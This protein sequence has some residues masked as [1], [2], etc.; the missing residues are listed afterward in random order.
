M[1]KSDVKK[2]KSRL[3]KTGG[4]KQSKLAEEFNISRSLVSDIWTE[5]AH[6]DVPWPGGQRPSRTKS[7]GQRKNTDYDPTDERIRGLEAE[8]VLLQDELRMERKRAK[9]NAKS[10]GLFKSVVDALENE[11]DPFSAL[12]KATRLKSARGAIREHCV[13]H[14][15]DGHHDQIVVPDECGGL[16]RYDFPISCA[17]AEKYVDTVLKWTQRTLSPQFR[18][19][20]L[21]ILAYGDHTSGEIHGHTNRS[22]FRNQFKNCF[23]IGRL[24][25]LMIRDLAPHFDQVNVVYVPG[26]HGRR[27]VKKDYHGAQD[28]W[29]FLV[30]EIARLHCEN[31][32]NVAF[33]IPNAF[34]VNLSINEIGF[35]ISHGDDVRS[36][37]GIPYYGL[38][39]R[40]RNMA[41]IAHAQDGP[42]IRYYCVGHFHKPGSLG[43]GDGEILV[44]GPWV[45]TDSYAYN[46][47]AGY[48]EPSQWIH[49]VHK[50]KGITWRLKVNL[51]SSDETPSRYVLSA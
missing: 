30:G 5:R 27:S 39:R 45:A 37:L 16:E 17:R 14:L 20:V 7:G 22:Y 8:V 50:D 2:L 10:E 33:L 23:A 25:A 35:N 32:T 12:P 3:H 36:A 11:I 9:A 42:R 15:S 38:Q 6:V 4:R 40:Q 28:N 21:D 29:D 24:H 18:F 34:S 48:T 43:D 19:P 44:N 47:F 13:M 46:R 51:K 41:A 31:L 1:N 49:G 26:N